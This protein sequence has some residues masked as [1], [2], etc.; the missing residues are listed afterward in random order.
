MRTASAAFACALC[1]LGG[2]TAHAY[3]GGSGT[4][5]GTAVSDTLPAGEQPTVTASGSAITVSWAQSPFQGQPIGTFNGGGYVVARRPAGGGAAVTPSA[6]CDTTI[7]GAAATLS[8]EELDVPPG[9]WT[10]T[11]TPVLMTWTGETSPASAAVA[12]IPA[13]VQ[14]ATA[15]QNPTAT[16]AT[17]DVRVG[18]AAVT[19]ADGYNVYRRATAGSYDYSSP[20]NGATPLTGTSY[21]D[22]GSGLTAGTTYAYVVRAVQGTPAAETADSNEQSATPVTRPTAP[23]GV[24]ATAMAAADVSV[25]W[26]AVAGSAGYNVYRRTS[27]G[28]YDYATPLNGAS[29]VTATSFTDL[30]AVNGTAYHYAVRAVI[31]GTGGTPVESFD[32]SES[33]AITADSTATPQPTSVTIGADAGPLQTVATCGF[34]ADTRFVNLAG[35]AAVP[36]A[37]V[38]P[39]PEPEQSVTVSA[40]T[41]GSTPVTTTVV[42]ASTTV[43]LSLDVS[44]LL[45]GT[46]TVTAS[47]ADAAGNA[48]PTQS[49]TTAAHKDTAAELSGLGYIDYFKG[50]ADRLRGTSECGARITAVQTTGPA[51]GSTYPTSGI[52]TV[53]GTATFNTFTV[54]ALRQRSY[55]YDVTA[56]DLAANA[57]TVAISGYASR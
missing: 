43:N 1:L 24:T 28:V 38:I 40:A 49:P 31:T 25:G 57:A 46:L 22:A 15:P 11:V 9:S 12:T 37:I 51:P 7:S 36:V 48:S 39:E 23:T 3:W 18:W 54:A 2:S 29:P 50:T 17:G 45:D 47:T 19:G 4:G 53:G 8:C 16:Q 32:G 33:A 44:A 10:Y 30:A 56:T 20:L 27:A 52:Y 35:M 21:D 5:A 26:N 6:G 34:A 13:P 41:P 14:A 42:A 55:A